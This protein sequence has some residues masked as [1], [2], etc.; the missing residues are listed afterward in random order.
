M[1]VEK[2]FLFMILLDILRR[3]KVSI[4]YIHRYK[5]HPI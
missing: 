2:E 4:T 3:K 1:A 5:K